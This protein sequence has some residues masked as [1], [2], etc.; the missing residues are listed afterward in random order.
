[1]WSGGGTKPTE[2]TDFAC[3]YLVCSFCYFIFKRR[4]ILETMAS[5]PITYSHVFMVLTFH[6]W[7]CSSCL[8]STLCSIWPSWCTWKMLYHRSMVQISVLG[9]VFHH[10]TGKEVQELKFLRAPR[11]FFLFLF[12]FF[13]CVFLLLCSSMKILPLY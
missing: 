6:L 13:A 12:F 3:M 7:W 9:S 10:R 2:H 5:E 8:W 11:F 4:T 1:M